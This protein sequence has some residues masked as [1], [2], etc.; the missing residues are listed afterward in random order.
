MSNT[1]KQGWTG[2]VDRVLRG[3]IEW[4]STLCRAIGEVHSVDPPPLRFGCV[5]ADTFERALN[6]PGL[7]P[8]DGDTA[9]GRF[10]AHVVHAWLAKWVGAADQQGCDRSAALA[11]RYIARCFAARSLEFKN[12]LV[13]E[14]LALT[15]Q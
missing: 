5:L 9:Q 10:A 3:E 6:D 12:A 1:S 4:Q 14:F 8:L 7:E 2:L 11:N 15:Q 13:R